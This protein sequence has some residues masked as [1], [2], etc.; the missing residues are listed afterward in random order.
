MADL[1]PVVGCVRGEFSGLSALTFVLPQ[2]TV[3]VEV[4]PEAVQGQVV[5][6]WA[7][8]IRLELCDGS[9]RD[10]RVADDGWFRL[11]PPPPGGFRLELVGPDGACL[12]T[13]WVGR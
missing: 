5:P 2:L 4:T 8:R 13:P 11:G 10:A 3:E 7:R 12:R 9:T 1:A 6:A